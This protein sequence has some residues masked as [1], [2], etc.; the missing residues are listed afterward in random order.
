MLLIWQGKDVV[1]VIRGA[2]YEIEITVKLQ[3]C[4]KS[5]EC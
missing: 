3:L 4:N 2:Y 5:V 1:P